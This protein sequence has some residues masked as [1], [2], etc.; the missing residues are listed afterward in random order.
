MSALTLFVA[1]WLIH[2]AHAAWY[3][4]AFAI[5]LFFMDTGLY[6]QIVNNQKILGKKMNLIAEFLGKKF[7]DKNDEEIHSG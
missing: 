4:Y 2:M 5:I 6:N 3:W 1:L 7:G